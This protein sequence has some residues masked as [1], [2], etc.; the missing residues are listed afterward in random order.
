M[1]IIRGGLIL[2]PLGGKNYLV[3][4]GKGEIK[5]MPIKLT[6]NHIAQIIR[7]NKGI[8]GKKETKKDLE[9]KLQQLF[10]R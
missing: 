2:T 7:E 8:V 5:E 3:K 1:R 10:K 6:R 4:D 9:M